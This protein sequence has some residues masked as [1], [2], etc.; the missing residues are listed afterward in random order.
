VSLG[1]D[2][3]DDGATPTTW[4]D[5][6]TT[7]AAGN[8]GTKRVKKW[9]NEDEGGG[10]WAAYWVLCALM[11]GCGILTVLGILCRRACKTQRRAVRAEVAKILPGNSRPGW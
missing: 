11:I 2:D 7:T 10:P 1:V 5:D 8:E 4:A 3:D 9:S 6:G